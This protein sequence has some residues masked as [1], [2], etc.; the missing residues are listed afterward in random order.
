ML[1]FRKIYFKMVILFLNKLK[2]KNGMSCQCFGFFFKPNH[3][4]NWLLNNKILK[5]FNP[6]QPYGNKFLILINS[7]KS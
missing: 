4:N 7:Q 2:K 6:E 3:Q 1:N 5:R